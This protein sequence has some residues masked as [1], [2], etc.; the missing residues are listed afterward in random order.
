MTKLQEPIRFNLHEWFCRE[1]RQ[2]AKKQHTTEHLLAR[3]IIE[4]AIR[5]KKGV[6]ALQPKTGR[7]VAEL[8]NHFGFALEKLVSNLAHVRWSVGDLAP[9]LSLTRYKL[10]E[11]LGRPTSESTESREPA[12]LQVFEGTDQP[13]EFLSPFEEEVEATLGALSFGEY[14]DRGRDFLR[15]LNDAIRQLHYRELPRVRREV[16]AALEIA[17]E[18]IDGLPSHPKT[19]RVPDHVCIEHRPTSTLTDTTGWTDQEVRARL[20]TVKKT[21]AYDK[22]FNHLRAWWDAFER[23]NTRHPSLVLRIA[24]EIACRGATISDF[25]LARDYS[26]ACCLEANLHF[27]DALMAN[28]R[29]AQ[30]KGREASGS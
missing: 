23:E 1:L 16:A 22:A 30:R 19:V 2:A 20:E 17:R 3:R 21:I 25:V 24:E 28:K 29:H 15:E 5:E 12:S 9:E 27:L 10:L 8:N 13:Y 18:V 4:D 26:R 7:T 11:A 6:W 14:L